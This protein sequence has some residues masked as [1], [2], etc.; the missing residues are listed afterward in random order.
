MRTRCGDGED[1]ELMYCMTRN[2]QSLTRSRRRTQYSTN[3]ILVCSTLKGGPALRICVDEREGRLRWEKFVQRWRSLRCCRYGRR[4][5]QYIWSSCA[6]SMAEIY[7]S[8]N[9]G[10][11]ALGW[12]PD[13]TLASRGSGIDART[14]VT[15]QLADAIGD[16]ACLVF[17]FG[18]ICET[19]SC[20]V[21]RTGTLKMRDCVENAGNDIVWKTMGYLCLLQNAKYGSHRCAVCYHRRDSNLLSLCVHTRQL[22]SENGI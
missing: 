3:S 9:V 2:N 13:G 11:T 6:H 21:T 19:A 1:T 5:R 4:T 7:T 8:A 12:R 14:G 22:R 15:G 16:F 20:P 17:L 18:G 10:G